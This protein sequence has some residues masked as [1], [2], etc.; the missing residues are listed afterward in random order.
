[1]KVGYLQ[2]MMPGQD[3]DA[4]TKKTAD[5]GFDTIQLG[6]HD[7]ACVYDPDLPGQV[8]AV[9]KKYGITIS[10]VRARWTGPIFWDLKDGPATLG[11]VP[12]EYRAQRVEDI[13]DWGAFAQK[14]GVK[15]IST[16]LGFIPSNPWHPD[17]MGTVDAL[18]YICRKLKKS[19]MEFFIETGQ[20]H[21]VCLMR[22]Y[23]DIGGDIDNLF[24]N[25]DPG[26]LFV[27][28]NANGMDAI[29]MFAPYIKE[30]HAKDGL[31]PTSGY[32]LG[33]QCK[34]GEGLVD[35]PLF[36]RKL[37]DFGFTGV[38]CIENE[39]EREGLI[40]AEQRYAEIV[41]SKEYLEGLVREICG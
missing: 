31:Y 29:D 26:N 11:L 35:F 36:I 24:I 15:V 20:E 40:T 39:R 7:H 10:E 13:L 6:F 17:Y 9:M 22:L 37:K 38:L 23:E 34:M 3:L 18:G 1:M 30:V 25:Y 4:I 33:L 32:K 14:I 16:H 21:P 41:E 27:Y 28:G 2:N 12:P 8:N 19:G 5:M